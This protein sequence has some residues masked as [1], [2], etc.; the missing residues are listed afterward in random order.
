MSREKW[1]V[2]HGTVVEANNRQQVRGPGRPRT[3]EVSE[4]EYRAYLETLDEEQAA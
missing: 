4:A 1:V 2:V 3:N